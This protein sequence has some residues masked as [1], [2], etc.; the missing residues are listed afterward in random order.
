MDS[1]LSHLLDILT[2]VGKIQ[3]QD[4]TWALLHLRKP[5]SYFFFDFD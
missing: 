3:F 1:L 2:S 5:V 4:P